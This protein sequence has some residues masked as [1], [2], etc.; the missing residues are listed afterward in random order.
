MSARELWADAIRSGKP[1]GAVAIV[2]ADEQG[3]TFTFVPMNEALPKR[4]KRRLISMLD[5]TRSP[6]TDTF[7]CPR[8]KATMSEVA[9][10]APLGSAPGLIAYECPRCVYVTSVLTPG[11]HLV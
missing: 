6:S 4:P 8:C 9:K 11:A 5:Q 7:L 3:G 10:I 1:L 2:I